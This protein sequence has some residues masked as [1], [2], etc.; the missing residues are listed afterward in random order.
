MVGYTCS[1]MSRK[2]HF[3]RRSH[4]ELAVVVRRR[5]D[6]A[7]KTMS[8]KAIPDVTVYPGNS[9]IDEIA[10]RVRYERVVLASETCSSE[11]VRVLSN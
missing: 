9:D 5:N 6:P 2:L 4:N 8:I 3:Q 10:G 11:V 7:R 1:W